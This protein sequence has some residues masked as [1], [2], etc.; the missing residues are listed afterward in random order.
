MDKIVNIM[1][2]INQLEDV[3]QLSCHRN[4]LNYMVGCKHQN[5][6]DNYEFV[7]NEVLFKNIQ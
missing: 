6:Y 2:G 7:N 5:L 3:E 4:C 1:F